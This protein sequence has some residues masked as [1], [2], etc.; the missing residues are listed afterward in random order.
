VDINDSNKEVNK[1]CLPQ[2]MAVKNSVFDTITV[3]RE[4]GFWSS[5]KKIVPY[6][7]FSYPKLKIRTCPKI[8]FMVPGECPSSALLLY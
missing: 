8:F 2:V 1:K 7:R 3:G 6:K 5:S 4:G